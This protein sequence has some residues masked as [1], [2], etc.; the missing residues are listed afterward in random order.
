MASI[1]SIQD[2]LFTYQK[3]YGTEALM[4]ELNAFQK[5]S[6][7]SSCSSSVAPQE[8]EKSKK[9]KK[10]KKASSEGKEKKPRGPSAWNA[11]IEIVAGKGKDE[12]PEFSSWKAT[13]V[14]QKGNLKMI[15]ASE[16]KA[17]DPEGYKSFESGFKK[18]NP[19]PAASSPAESDAESEAP[20]VE[21]PVSSSASVT[22][23]G[24]TQKKKA[25][26]PKGSKNKPKDKD[27]AKVDSSDSEAEKAEKPKPK[28]VA[29]K[30]AKK[31]EEKPAAVPLPDSDSEEEG[32]VSEMSAIT[33]DG[34]S[35]FWDEASG[36]VFESI[37][38]AMGDLA[39]TF[40][41]ITLTPA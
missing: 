10:G 20:K 18:S 7:F 8:P 16:M 19:A 28:K 2:I 15:F 39:G 35:Y 27:S 5:G 13:Q 12:T 3:V 23:E 40:D 41:G 34:V 17:K 25:G 21:A 31:A 11:F 37:D 6:S 14:D 24:S 30:V 29:K 32:E 33:I 22:S 1:K 4:A 9:S 38:G 36:K 26:R